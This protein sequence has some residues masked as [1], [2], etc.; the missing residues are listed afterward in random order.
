MP[1]NPNMDNVGHFAFEGVRQYRDLH[2]VVFPRKL[3][4]V[5]PQGKAIRE[6]LLV[7]DMW[8]PDHENLHRSVSPLPVLGYYA[9]Q[10]VA[11]DMNSY[12]ADPLD[13]IDDFCFA[14]ENANMHPKCKPMERKLG[15]LAIETI[16]EQ[17]PYI[18]S[19]R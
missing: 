15:E 18:R 17:I 12:Y 7:R 14:V 6:A 10:R 4:E 11:R 2:H 16:R 9:L 1:H 13:G 8:R 19:I 3:H 5:Y